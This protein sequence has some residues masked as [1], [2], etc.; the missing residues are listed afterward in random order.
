[1]VPRI[2][3]AGDDTLVLADGFSCGTQIRDLDSGGRDGV[4]LAELLA[5]LPRGREPDHDTPSRGG[6]S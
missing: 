1:M 3:E 6:T 5:D 4:H 2:R